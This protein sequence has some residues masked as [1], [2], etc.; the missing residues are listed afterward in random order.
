MTP[1]GS[2]ERV[3][4]EQLSQ[5]RERLAGLAEARG[6]ERLVELLRR[7][8]S[9][10]ERLEHGDWG[11]CVVCE[12]T[13]E[14]SRLMADPTLSICLECLSAEE[15]RA[16]EHDLQAAVRVQAALLPPRTLEHE[17]W[18]IAV[19]WEPRGAVSGDHIDLLKPRAPGEPLHLLLG[20]VAGKGVAAS[21]IQSQLH[22]FLRALAGG[23]EGLAR[24]LGRVNGLLSEA[25]LPS[26]YATLIALRLYPGGKAE[27][28]NA[29]HPWPLLADRRG[30]RP[31][32]GSNLP[33][34]LL[35][36]AEYSSRWLQL[37]VGDTLLLYTDGLTEAENGAGEELG[38]GRAAAALRRAQDRPLPELL[39][40][41]RQTMIDF[42]EGRPRGDDLTLV[43]LR[44]TE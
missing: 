30:T 29:G 3:I 17:G 10:L 25:T 20:D 37:E 7:V 16:L 40:A 42:L 12:G 36:D 1:I 39:A 38:I 26:A 44:R 15:R 34:G 13:V 23:E 21:L 22:A 11:I 9:A 18:D 41:C 8:D 32:E 6:E 28:A 2:V 4:L 35:P 33:L 31:V 43:A 14:P 19:H 24:L 27:L 5:R